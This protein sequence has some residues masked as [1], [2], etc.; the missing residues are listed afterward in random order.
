MLK[1]RVIPVLLWDGKQAVQSTHFKR[2]H[3]PVGSMMQHVE[4]FERRQIDELIILDVEATKER[5]A[6]LYSEIQEYTSKLFAPLTVGGGVDSLDK[7]EKLLKAGADKIAVNTS[8]YNSCDFVYDAARKF[9]SQCIVAS[10][11]NVYDNGANVICNS[12]GT[13][14]QGV[15]TRHVCKLAEELG[16]GEILLTDVWANGTM[17]GYNTD[18]I[19]ECSNYV[20]IPVIANGGCGTLQHVEYALHVGASAIAASSMFLFKDITPKDVSRHLHKQGF[21][22][23]I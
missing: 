8:L 15:P 14:T 18:L 2:P 6:P 16:C 3:R 13:E 11:N 22:A 20:S 12:D 1:T 19:A 5:R 9:G 23:R 10:I 17:Q 21:P 4:N 7:I